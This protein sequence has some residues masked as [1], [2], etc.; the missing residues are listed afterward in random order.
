MQR[1]ITST[2]IH[3]ALTDSGRGSDDD[4]QFRSRHEGTLEG[5][6]GF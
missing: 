5:L 4:A 1:E 3:I 6:T 2:G